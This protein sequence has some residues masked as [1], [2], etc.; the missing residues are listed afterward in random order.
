MTDLTDKEINKMVEHYKKQRERDKKRYLKRRENPEWVE[1][2][3]QR[4]RAH[5]QANK[6][7]KKLKY[8]NNRDFV[9][10]R[11][12][13]YYYKNNNRINEFV[14]KFPDKVKILENYGLVVGTTISTDNSSS[15]V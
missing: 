13:Y 9:I 5:Y 14:D 8:E 1:K 3:R 15:S 6:E 11:S 12:H 2:N 10:A 4:A 7:A